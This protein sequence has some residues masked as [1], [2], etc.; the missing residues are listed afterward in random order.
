MQIT[1]REQSYRTEL[2]IN[3][4]FDIIRAYGYSKLSD[5]QT[6]FSLSEDPTVDEVEAISSL[7]VYGIKEAMRVD[8]VKEDQI[9]REAPSLRDL[10]PLLL[11]DQSIIEGLVN[12]LMEHL[13]G[14]E[15]TGESESSSSS[16]KKKGSS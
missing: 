12:E 8:G 9:E 1:V 6:I 4:A 13:P 15:E 16:N 7:A 3:V 11:G 2:N 10:N 14:E 5:L